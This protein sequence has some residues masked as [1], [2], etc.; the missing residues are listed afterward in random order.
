MVR[1][2]AYHLLLNFL[3][4]IA[5]ALLPFYKE[6]SSSVNLSSFFI[7]ILESSHPPFHSSFI[8]IL[9]SLATLLYA[10]RL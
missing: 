10:G 9:P 3:A 2:G 8:P 4:N 7:R 5:S 1:I 6:I